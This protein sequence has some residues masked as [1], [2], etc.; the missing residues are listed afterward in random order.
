VLVGPIFRPITDRLLISREKLSYIVDSTTAAV[1]VLLPFTAWGAYVISIIEK[2]YERLSYTGNP[3]VDFVA[4]VPY[5]YYSIGCLLMVLLIALTG[6]DYGPMKRAESR[7]KNEGK[8]LSDTAKPIRAAIEIDVPAG[9]A[10]SVWDM[11]IPI[12]VLIVTVFGM[13]L[14]TGGFPE[15]PILAA[16]GGA[17]SMT[18][19]NIAFFAAAIAAI[20]FTVKSRVFPLSKAI[21]TFYEGGGSMFQAVLILVLAWSIGSVCKGVG[22]SDYVVSISRNAL[23]PSSMYLVV[24]F[25][26]CFTAFSTGTSWGVFAIFLPIAIPL[27]QAIGA[28]I[29]P[30][31]GVVLSGG[32]FGDHCSPIS[33]TTVLSSMGSSA[34]HI[35]HVATQLPYALTVALCAGIGYLIAGITSGP[36]IGL[37]VTIILMGAAVFSIGRFQ[38]GERSA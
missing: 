35:D 31:V 30:A 11:I 26:S 37:A 19:L 8:V 36:F 25:A 29:A 21:D 23:T 16:L 34:D 3:V 9:A 6:I 24:F 33:D 10:P 32:I 28:P 18:S 12:V 5:Q 7:A 13:F 4:G 2:E 22:T 15:K 38:N 27:A 17:S 20:I 1:P 14:W